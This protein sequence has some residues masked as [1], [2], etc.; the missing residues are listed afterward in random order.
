MPVHLVHSLVKDDA[1]LEAKASPY[2]GSSVGESTQ[3]SG[4]I[5]VAIVDDSVVVRGLISRWLREE[6]G[7]EVVGT[8]RSGREIITNKIGRASCRERV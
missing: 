2:N 8:Y 5:R 1:K 3:K 7:I 4:L 6:D